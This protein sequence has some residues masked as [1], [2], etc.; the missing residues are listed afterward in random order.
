MKSFFKKFTRKNFIFYIFLFEKFQYRKILFRDYYKN[1]FF[2]KKKYKIKE[3]N[4]I[5][6]FTPNRVNHFRAQT[7]FSKEP[8]TLDWIDGFKKDSNFFDIGSNVGDLLML[9]S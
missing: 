9:C 5:Y 4:Y 3:S 8:E 7:F 2:T 6:L 1:N